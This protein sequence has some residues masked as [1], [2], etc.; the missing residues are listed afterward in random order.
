MDYGLLGSELYWESI[1]GKNKVLRHRT[2][3]KIPYLHNY[4][5]TIPNIVMIRS[6]KTKQL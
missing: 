4:T 3:S 6:S 5:Y 1:G 2:D